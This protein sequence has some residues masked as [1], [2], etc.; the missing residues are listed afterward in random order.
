MASLPLRML[1]VLFTVVSLPLVADPLVR[2][3]EPGLPL[4]AVNKTRPDRPARRPIRASNRSA[5]TDF[6]L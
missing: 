5:R 2:F 4:D 6:E 1:M 3:G